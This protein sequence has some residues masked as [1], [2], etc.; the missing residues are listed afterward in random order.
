MGASDSQQ[1]PDTS[2]SKKGADDSHLPIHESGDDDM[3]DDTVAAQIGDGIGD[4]EVENP[5]QPSSHKLGKRALFRNSLASRAIHH[6]RGSERD[7]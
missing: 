2:T 1:D 6:H 5:A 7:D 4:D 3:N